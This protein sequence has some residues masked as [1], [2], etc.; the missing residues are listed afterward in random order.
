MLSLVRPHSCYTLSFSNH[1][2]GAGTAVPSS[3]TPERSP[4]QFFAPPPHQALIAQH[5]L[6]NSPYS[7]SSYSYPVSSPPYMAQPQPI[8]YGSPPHSYAHAQQSHPHL[9]Q[10]QPVPHLRARSVSPPRSRR[11]SPAPAYHQATA[12]SPSTSYGRTVTPILGR[13]TS[14]SPGSSYR[15]Q[16]TPY[17]RPQASVSF[18]PSSRSTS[19]RTASD[20][21]EDGDTPLTESGVSQVAFAGVASRRPISPTA[22]SVSSRG[23]HQTG[24][25]M[26]TPPPEG[27]SWSHSSLA[28]SSPR[29]RTTNNA[30]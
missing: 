29:S 9:Y 17:P 11:M 19:H 1:R 14:P 5:M 2:F 6:S 25:A 10:H 15:P 28:G 30:I 3:P 18:S 27:A 20:D 13:Q 12:P 22:F 21:G 24:H 16:N 7:N 26:P 4:Q 8:A 23:T